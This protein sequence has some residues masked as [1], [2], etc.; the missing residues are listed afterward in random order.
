MIAFTVSF[1]EKGLL[2][3]IFYLSLVLIT[4]P[5]VSITFPM[6]F[7]YKNDLTNSIL[8]EQVF[9][10]EKKRD[11]IQMFFKLAIKGVETASSDES[12]KLSFDGE[13]FISTV[14]GIL[15]SSLAVT[16]DVE[17][18]GVVSTDGKLLAIY[19]E[20]KKEEVS[21]SIKE[22][23]PSV[24]FKNGA[25]EIITTKEWIIIYRG[26]LKDKPIRGGVVSWIK[27][28]KIDKML[29][30]KSRPE[31]KVVSFWTKADREIDKIFVDKFFNNKMAFTKTSL[32]LGKLKYPIVVAQAE[33]DFLRN[34]NSTVSRLIV[35]SV[36]IL[37]AAV[38]SLYFSIRFVENTI[39]IFLQ[40]L[41]SEASMLSAASTSL[42]QISNKMIDANLL[43]KEFVWKTA[44]AID[45][46]K[47]TS[48]KTGESASISIQLADKSSNQTQEG[49]KIIDRMTV[50]IDE[51]N[52]ST[53]KI[54]ETLKTNNHDYSSMAQNISDIE[55]KTRVIND[56]VFQ[57]KLLSFNASV[58]AARAGEQGKGFAV[59]AEE[60]GSL[61]EMSGKAAK[62]IGSLLAKSIGNVNQVLEKNNEQISHVHNAGEKQT[63]QTKKGAEEC[64]LSFDNVISSV[65]EVEIHIKEIS[66]VIEE[67]YR[68]I[69]LIQEAMSQTEQ[70]FQGSEALAFDTVENSK[71]IKENG[72]RLSNLSIQIKKTLRG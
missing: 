68:G 14:S 30:I 23:L 62:E 32:D 9:I 4:I 69:E 26:I 44:Q 29:L 8:K 10:S 58:E 54:I 40:K 35:L 34:I 72:E 41:E 17:G 51:S 63:S 2:K 55:I 57:T 20:S 59:V 11:D 45:Q 21:S 25:P 43:L 5:F 67:Q 27:K 36:V 46:L 16:P 33:K 19:P 22:F 50:V 42:D 13:M 1:L 53:K 64:M 66:G 65:R 52:E 28:T 12:I 61:A 3:K 15:Q 39:V 31:I 6:I 49:K 71:S 38:L 48:E 7:N 60:I 47:G 37:L 70:S 18:M 24:N 56:I